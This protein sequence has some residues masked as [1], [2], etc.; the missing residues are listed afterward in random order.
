MKPRDGTESDRLGWRDL[1]SCYRWLTRASI[2]TDRKVRALAIGALEF[3]SAAGNLG[4]ILLLIFGLNLLDRR[5]RGGGELVIIEDISVVS[6]LTALL[7][8]GVASAAALLLGALVSM[9]AA[10]LARK[11]ARE[12]QVRL[13]GE[14]LRDFARAPAGSLV[15]NANQR[16]LL[17]PN[18]TFGPQI[19]GVAAETI[20]RLARPLSL[21][22]IFTVAIAFL[23]WWLLL[24]VIAITGLTVPFMYGLHRRTAHHSGQVYGEA[25]REVLKDIGA[26]VRKVDRL[27]RSGRDL[28]AEV[29]R[30]LEENQ[31]LSSVLESYDFW[32]LSSDRGQFL[33]SASKAVATQFLVLALAGVVLVS[34]SVSWPS[35]IGLLLAGMRLQDAVYAVL[36][37]TLA[38]SRFLPV[39]KRM[40]EF[41]TVLAAAASPSE[42]AAESRSAPRGAGERVLLISKTPLLKSTLGYHLEALRKAEWLPAAKP[43]A[44]PRIRAIQDLS[45]PAATLGGL[46]DRYFGQGEATAEDRA[47]VWR[48]L[49]EQDR[50]VFSRGDGDVACDEVWDRLGEQGKLLCMLLDTLRA[51]DLVV[52]ALPP[53][54]IS[55]AG[56][57]LA[58]WRPASA[59]DI[60]VL[61]PSEPE[62]TG[63]YDQVIRGDRSVV[64]QTVPMHPDEGIL[65]QDELESM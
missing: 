34:A 4:A 33:T 6:D 16:N 49:P 18:F 52:I 20:L 31:N 22:V 64:D 53:A 17:A 44:D 27:P 3:V 54:L 8:I 48:Q 37:R 14:L 51:A 9:K 55:A 7:L 65:A 59:Q 1:A 42:R 38:L 40:R 2:T 30:A 43:G 41:R 39:V 28:E 24:V 11:T 60:V 10:V 62:D 45:P 63:A 61:L 13:M 47:Q 26:L 15:L 57:V 29:A 21:I 36:V 12:F 32:K 5:A 35:V 23:K 56:Q 19:C 25:R 50:E 58:R 46:L